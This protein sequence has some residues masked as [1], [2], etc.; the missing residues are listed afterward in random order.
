MEVA[1]ISIFFTLV[2]D[3]IVVKAIAVVLLVTVALL[4]HH[5][6]NRPHEDAE[7]LDQK[8]AVVVTRAC[9]MELQVTCLAAI[10]LMRKEYLGISLI[11]VMQ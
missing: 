5:H 7:D 6:P 9:V 4:T 10:V 3:E 2:E 8:S 1:V 11:Q